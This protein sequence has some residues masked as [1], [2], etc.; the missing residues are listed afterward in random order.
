METVK[1]LRVEYASSEADEWGVMNIN[2]KYSAKII[3]PHKL[4]GLSNEKLYPTSI[5]G[6]MQ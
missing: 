3:K 5:K 1:N 2:D 4:F 6:T